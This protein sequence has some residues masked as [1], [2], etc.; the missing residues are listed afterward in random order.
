MKNRDSMN[1]DQLRNRGFDR[2]GRNMQSG[3]PAQQ[4]TKRDVSGAGSQDRNMK[5]RKD[6]DLDPLTKDVKGTV[7]S[8]KTGSATDD[9]AGVADIDRDLKR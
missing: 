2:E 1:N 4:K 5:H 6:T 8:R 3:T 7:G 9:I